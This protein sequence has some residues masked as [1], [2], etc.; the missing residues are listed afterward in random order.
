MA[1]DLQ[2]IITKVRRLT[3]S[4]SEAQISTAE[5]TDYINTFVLYDF[6]EQLRLFNL[7]ETLTFFLQPYID[8]YT[9]NPTDIN[10]PLYDFKNRYITTHQ[11]MYVSGNQ[12]LFSQ[13]R[14]QFFG[15][16]PLTNFIQLI[17]VG[18]GT[19][20]SFSGVLPPPAGP[21]PP[22]TNPTSVLMPVLRNQ[23]LFD[24][25]TTANGGLSV[26]DDGLGNLIGDTNPIGSIDYVNRN[27]SFDF[28]LAPQAGVPINAQT[29]PYQPSL[30]KSCLFFDGSFTFRP[31]PDQPYRVNM[32]VFVQPAAL[33]N[34]ADNPKLK[35]WWQYIA[36]GAAKKIFEDRTDTDSVQLLMPE[37]KMQERLI[38]RRTLVQQTKERTATIYTEQTDLGASS[39]GWGWGSGNVG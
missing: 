22:F 25:I 2:A 32:E 33:L 18:D 1:A 6:P 12:V 7:R 23:V 30:P 8:T 20:T 4:P 37:F 5:I 39:N 36:Y 11:P 14:E 19:T 35:E 27:Y 13:S 38:L 15:L 26:Y 9:T 29:V 31:V 34:S 16:Y 17:G 24:S 10:D 21:I 3:R 28:T